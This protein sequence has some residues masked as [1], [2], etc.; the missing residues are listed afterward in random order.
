[1][2]TPDKKLNTLVAKVLDALDTKGEAEALSLLAWEYAREA[3]CYIIPEEERDYDEKSEWR[4]GWVAGCKK[5]LRK[6]VQEALSR[7]IDLGKKAWDP[8]VEL[9]VV[10]GDSK[11]GLGALYFSKLPQSRQAEIITRAHS[12]LERISSEHSRVKP[13]LRKHYLTEVIKEGNQ[14]EDRFINE[15]SRGKKGNFFSAWCSFKHETVIEVPRIIDPDDLFEV[16]IDWSRS[17]DDLIASFKAS[18]D[19]LRNGREWDKSVTGKKGVGLFLETRAG[20]LSEKRFLDS[21][22]ANGDKKKANK[23]R[24]LI[25]EALADLLT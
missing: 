6:G 1:M 8:L 3:C 9:I 14:A 25:A 5:E 18:L 17:D 23:A 21:G 2:S 24:T 11:L 10:C 7:E 12:I 22:K 16:Q 19:E 20:W 4:G 15:F 13:L